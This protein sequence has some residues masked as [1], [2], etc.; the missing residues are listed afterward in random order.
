MPSAEYAFSVF[1][2]CPFDSAYRPI[3]EAIVFTVHDCGYIARCAL[4][5][6]DSSEVRIEKIA[7]II[8]G[9][10][11]GIHDISRRFPSIQHAA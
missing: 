1:V 2:N 3:F 6:D 11:F 5:L 10:K 4:E 8:A 7:R 9:C